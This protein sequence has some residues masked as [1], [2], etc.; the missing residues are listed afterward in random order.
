MRVSKK[1]ESI[2]IIDIVKSREDSLDNKFKTVKLRQLTFDALHDIKKNNNLRS[3]DDAV[4]TLLL[5]V[6]LMLDKEKSK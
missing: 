3:I 1:T 2:N 5:S 4:S 6:A